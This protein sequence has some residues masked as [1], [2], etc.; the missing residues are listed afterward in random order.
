LEVV[1]NAPCGIS[2]YEEDDYNAGFLKGTVY[3]FD[4]GVECAQR[5]ISVED[6]LP[7][8]L[9]GCRCSKAVIASIDVQ[10]GFKHPIITT[11]DFQ[12]DE[13]SYKSYPITHWRPIELK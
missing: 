3:G 10:D 7:P 8:K 4:R 12:L 9:G 2:N 11:Y 6:E 1:R 5:W 13:W